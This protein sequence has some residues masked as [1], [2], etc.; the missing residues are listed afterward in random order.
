MKRYN[1]IRAAMA[2]AATFAASAMAPACTFGNGTAEAS[3]TVAV[4]GTLPQAEVAHVAPAGA[5]QGQR[6]IHIDK[7]TMTLSVIAPDGSVEA[8]FGCATGKVPGHKQRRGDMRTPEGRFTISQIQ[9]ASSWTHDFGDGKRVIEGAYGPRFI[10]LVTPGFS[11]IGI[12]GTHDPASIG[13]RASEGCIRLANENADSLARM[14]TVGTVVVIT[15][16]DADDAVNAQ[17]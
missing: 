11:G 4:A 8:E 15:P 2:I 17:R 1:M 5:P 13:T 16:G 6:Y 3:D 7:Q 10:R 14:V 9:D 12:H